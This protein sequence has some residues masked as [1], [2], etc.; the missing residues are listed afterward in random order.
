MSRWELMGNYMVNTLRYKLLGWFLHFVIL[1]STTSVITSVNP[2]NNSEPLQQFV[3][4]YKS[5]KYCAINNI[6]GRKNIQ[7]KHLLSNSNAVKCST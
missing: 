6:S 4:I 5:I 2:F 7:L 3:K 1:D